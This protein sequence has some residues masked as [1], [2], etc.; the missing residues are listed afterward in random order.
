M[1]NMQCKTQNDR[2]NPPKGTD[3][4]ER[5][6]TFAV[7][8]LGVVKDL[9]KTA[10]ARHIAGQLLRSGTSPGANYEEA[11]G[12]ESRADFV[13]KLG[14][15]LKELRE[16]RYWLRLI[17]RAELLPQERLGALQQEADELAK[18]IAQSIVTARRKNEPARPGVDE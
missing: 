5:L 14:I 13:H 16:S 7:R 17:G 9:P 10:A 6:E 1:K 2:A 12:A 3:I 8:I 15:V 18:I 11:R 4:S